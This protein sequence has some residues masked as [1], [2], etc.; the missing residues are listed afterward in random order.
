[1]ASE[2]YCL[3]WTRGTYLLA[4]PPIPTTW[5][6]LV[7]SVPACSILIHELSTTKMSRKNSTNSRAVD[8]I[9]KLFARL[10]TLISPLPG[11]TPHEVLPLGFGEL[12]LVVGPLLL[13]HATYGMPDHITYH[14]TS[15]QATSPQGRPLGARSTFGFHLVWLLASN[16]NER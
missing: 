12:G 2:G 14:D 16:Q 5:T 15:S 11:H 7:A 8:S 6:L 4:S 13:T 10:R 3:R 9:T 1:M